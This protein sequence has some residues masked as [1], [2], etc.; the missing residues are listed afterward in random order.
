MRASAIGEYVKLATESSEKKNT[1]GRT[2]QLSK[3]RLPPLWSGQKFDRW[4]KEIEKWCNNDKLTDE[5]KYIDLLESLK[6][7]DG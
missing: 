3:P 1:T 4:K 2:T 6:K 5:E 7:N